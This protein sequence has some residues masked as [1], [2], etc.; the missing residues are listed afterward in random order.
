MAADAR[1]LI[2]EDDPIMQHVLAEYARSAGHE[3]SIVAN[4]AEGLA[5]A[6]AQ[7]F[8]IIFTEFS[9]SHLNGIEMVEAIRDARGANAETPAVLITA[10][11]RATVYKRAKCIGAADVLTKPVSYSA[12]CSA[13]ALYA[14]RSARSETRLDARTDA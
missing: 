6:E 12:F 5:A 13:V 4:G 1:I 11:D 14:K 3:Y 2:V 8:A 7:P 10:E 9:M